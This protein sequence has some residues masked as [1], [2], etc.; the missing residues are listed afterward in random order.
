MFRVRSSVSGLVVP[1]VPL[2]SS[3]NTVELAAG[4][5]PGAYLHASGMFT[6]GPLPRTAGVSAFTGDYRAERVVSFGV[7]PITIDVALT[8]CWRPSQGDVP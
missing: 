2:A 7:H 6:S 1:P 3:E 8:L 4:G 5:N